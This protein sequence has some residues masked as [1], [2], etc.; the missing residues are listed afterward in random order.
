MSRPSELTPEMMETVRQLTLTQARRVTTAREAT[1]KAEIEEI[2]K[3]QSEIEEK[4]RQLL[5]S[6]SNHGYGW[7]IDFFSDD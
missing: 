1:L 7:M 2:N 4:M 3:R 5:S 6:Q